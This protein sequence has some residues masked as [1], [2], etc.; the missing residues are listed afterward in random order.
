VWKRNG[1]VAGKR[2]KG[3]AGPDLSMTGESIERVAK[4]CK[5]GSVLF[6]AGAPEIDWG[7]V[8]DLA[9]STKQLKDAHFEAIGLLSQT[10]VPGHRIE[11]GK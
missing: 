7:L 9:A 2:A 4:A 11:L 3:M 8:Y 6:V 10:P 1:G 5:Q